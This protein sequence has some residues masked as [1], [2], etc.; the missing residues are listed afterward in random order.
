MLEQNLVGI[1]FKDPQSFMKMRAL[2]GD[3]YDSMNRE[4]Q[5][6]TSQNHVVNGSNISLSDFVTT[7]QPSSFWR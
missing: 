5:T 7:P 4:N 1:P 2:I 3:I 6:D